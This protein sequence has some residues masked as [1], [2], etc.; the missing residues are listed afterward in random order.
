MR[1]VT[2]LLSDSMATQEQLNSHEE[3][4]HIVYVRKEFY[5][6]VAARLKKKACAIR[7]DIDLR[8]GSR[9]NRKKKGRRVLG[10]SDVLCKFRPKYR[11]QVFMIPGVI[12]VKELGTETTAVL[13]LYKKDRTRTAQR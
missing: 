12:G 3:S 6:A 8:P 11:N 1:Q 13:S 10:R 4:W 2:G 5:E 9:F 7:T